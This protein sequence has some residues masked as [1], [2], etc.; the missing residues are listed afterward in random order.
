[1]RNFR[2]QFGFS[3]IEAIVYIS[4]FIALSLTSIISLL[5]TVRA[6]NHL[7]ITRDINDTAVLITER[8][9]HDIKSSTAVDI[10]NSTFDATPGRL[11]LTAVDTSGTSMT[12]EYFVQDELLHVKENGVD[13]GAL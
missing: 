1:M 9:T 8:L 6:F 10:S 5:D 3:L 13:Q 2:S 4:L 11:T 7:H 12:I